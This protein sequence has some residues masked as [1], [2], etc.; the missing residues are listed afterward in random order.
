MPP[1]SKP[2]PHGSMAA[3]VAGGKGFK[4]KKN[5]KGEEVKPPDGID[6]GS[7]VAPNAK[8]I[9]CRIGTHF[10]SK[11]IIKA[12]KYLIDQKEED[13]K[14]NSRDLKWGVDVVSMSFGV[15]KELDISTADEMNKLIERLSQLGVI[16]VASAGNYG[17]NKP[18]LFPASHHCVI[19][20]GALHKYS[21]PAP[22]NPSRDVGVYAPGANIAAPVV[23]VPDG[24]EM[25]SGSSCATPAIAG[26][27]ALK[28]QFERNK[29]EL[30]K[31][32]D[33]KEDYYLQKLLKGEKFHLGQIK[34]MFKDMQ[35]VD[36]P[37]VLDP[38]DYFRTK[39]RLKK[40]KM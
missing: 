12:L 9:I 7:G 8:L 34:D 1:F 27:V 11:Y 14:K 22:A 40:I 10:H 20:V 23:G 15:I 25:D 5:E 35:H 37:N 2:E 17:D 26:L 28:I 19:S 36:R 21:K 4:A 3:F 18:I 13:N 38:C 29:H 16:L 33:A 30:L 31:D 24:V 6:I 39:C 32:Q